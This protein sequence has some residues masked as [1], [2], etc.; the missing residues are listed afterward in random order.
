MSQSVH[1]AEITSVQVKRFSFIVMGDVQTLIKICQFGRG[2]AKPKLPNCFKL[3]ALTA[4]SGT[5]FVA[6][7]AI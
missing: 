1:R 5:N 4:Y 7:K 6:L 2:F 3:C